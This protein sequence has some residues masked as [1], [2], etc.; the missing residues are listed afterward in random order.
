MIEVLWKVELPQTL[1]VVVVT[2][3]YIIKVVLSDWKAERNIE[4]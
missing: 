2:W 3:L 4:F 1:Q